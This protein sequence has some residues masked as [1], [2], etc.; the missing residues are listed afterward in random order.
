MLNKNT[1][2]L[3]LG[4]LVIIVVLLIVLFYIKKSP[5]ESIT[6]PAPSPQANLE[7]HLNKQT[8]ADINVANMQ[9]E[10]L[11]QYPWYPKLPLQEK[12]YFVLFDLQKKVIRAKI[13][14][15]KSSAISIDDQVKSYQQEITER[16]KQLEVGTNKYSIEWFI[17]P[18]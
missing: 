18:E 1:I 12:N 10:I 9:E 13:Y 6:S 17:T 5:N 15:Q 16:L 2:L 3:L 7:D 8:Q 14:P 11:E 4:L